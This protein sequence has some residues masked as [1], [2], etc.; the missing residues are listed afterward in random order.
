MRLGAHPCKLKEGTKAQ[1]AYNDEL[2]YERHRHRFEFNNK[3]REQFENAGM[4]V[5]GES[6]DGHLVEIIELQDHPFFIGTQ[7]HP[8]FA[9]R[10]V[11]PH[12]L[13][14]EFIRA[15]LAHQNR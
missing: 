10:P 9:S 8:E 15:A 2:V 7:F 12:A 13:I 1:E 6:P 4:I 11:R 3:Y 5:A 14:R